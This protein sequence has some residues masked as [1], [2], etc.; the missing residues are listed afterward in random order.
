MAT[1]YF[2]GDILEDMIFIDMGVL[3][4]NTFWTYFWPTTCVAVAGYSL[5]AY[6]GVMLRK[7]DYEALTSLKKGRNPLLW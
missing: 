5:Q 7:E 4:F 3:D 1:S 2:L 6:L